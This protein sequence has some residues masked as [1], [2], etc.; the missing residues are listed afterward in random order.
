MAS[1][2]TAPLGD[3]R[4]AIQAGLSEAASSTVIRSPFGSLVTSPKRRGARRTIRSYFGCRPR[5]GSA[6]SCLSIRLLIGYG[7]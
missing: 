6:D 4:F 7:M 2:A 3:P 5:H 1:T